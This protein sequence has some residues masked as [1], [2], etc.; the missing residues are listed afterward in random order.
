[1]NLEIRTA[2]FPTLSTLVWK[3]LQLNL[4]FHIYSAPHEEWTISIHPSSEDLEVKDRTNEDWYSLVD[5][6]RERP[7][8]RPI[9]QHLEGKNLQTPISIVCQFSSNCSIKLLPERVAWCIRNSTNTNRITNGFFSSIFCSDIHQK[10]IF[11]TN[12]VGI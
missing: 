4:Q 9:P 7:W 8:R 1:M 6:E 11:I 3:Y 5:A 12:S 2:V 10:K